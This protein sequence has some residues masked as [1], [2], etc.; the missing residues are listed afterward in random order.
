M[1]SKVARDKG[2]AK[3]LGFAAFASCLLCS[4]SFS[5]AQPLSAKDYEPAEAFHIATIRVLVD[6]KQVSGPPEKL[7]CYVC[8]AL[9]FLPCK[10][11]VQI[12]V[13]LG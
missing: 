8:E 3:H 7:T 9:D 4:A 12:W 1:S 11:D 2:L 10:S 13:Q 6:T 5:V